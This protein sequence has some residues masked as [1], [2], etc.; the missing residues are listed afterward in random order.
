MR[1]STAVYGKLVLNPAMFPNL[2]V[3]KY[4]SDDCCALLRLHANLSADTVEIPYYVA[5]ASFLH[6]AHFVVYDRQRKEIVVAVRG[7]KS[8]EDV[9]TDLGADS[10]DLF[11]GGSSHSSILK[12]AGNVLRSVAPVLEKYSPEVERVTFTGHSLGGG[13]ATYLTLLF[14]ELVESADPSLQVRCFAFGAPGVC[15]VD[16]SNR[17]RDRVFSF[18][19]DQDIVPRLCFASVLELHER[20]HA[21]AM[22]VYDRCHHVYA[23]N[24]WGQLWSNFSIKAATD[25]VTDAAACMNWNNI[26]DA[27]KLGAGNGDSRKLYPLGR[28]FLIRQDGVCADLPPTQISPGISLAGGQRLMLDHTP[29]CYEAALDSIRSRRVLVSK[30]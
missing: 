29:P 21:A 24:Y 2:P 4:I 23:K 3:D 10:V 14:E 16:V 13:T 30:P 28:N 9:V 26:P 19:H 8:V 6:P 12:G 15:S 25:A 17:Y 27:A 1:I 7:T 11:V 18:C 20:A 5:E 22:T